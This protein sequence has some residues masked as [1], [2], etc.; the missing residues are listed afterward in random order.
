MIVK[1]YMSNYGI[2]NVRGGTY[3]TIKLTD[4][5]INFL[6]KEILHAN[7][8]CFNCGESGHYVNNCNEKLS[9]DIDVSYLITF[10]KYKGQKLGDLLKDTKYVE[11]MR[12]LYRPHSQIK[13]VLNKIE[14][15]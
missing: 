11:W 15:I 9:N 3:S 1:Q 12:S 7:N 10:G 4:S 13:I 6:Q 8:L 5:V 2:E 14:N